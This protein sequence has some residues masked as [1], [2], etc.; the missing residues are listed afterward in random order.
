M[1]DR[2]SLVTFAQLRL[3]AQYPQHRCCRGGVV[4]EQTIHA[5]PLPVLMRFALHDH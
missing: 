5:P 4:G 2:D 1:E 3:R